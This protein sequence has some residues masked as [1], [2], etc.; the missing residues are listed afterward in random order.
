MSIFAK[1]KMLALALVLGAGPAMAQDVPPGC[2]ERVYS[3]DHLARHPAQVVAALRLKVGDWMTEVAREG[4]I[5]VIPVGGAG[6]PTALG[7]FLICGNEAGAPLCQVECD[8]GAFE[9]VKWDA[10][11]MTFRTRYMLVGE[12]EGCGGLLDLAE[13]PGQFTSYRVNRVADGQCD[14]M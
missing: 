5:A 1:K 8:G 6:W 13:V 12:G 2:Y 11:G 14:G 9:V 7:Q 10:S 3:A 4:R